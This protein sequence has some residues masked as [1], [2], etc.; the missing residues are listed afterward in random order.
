MDTIFVYLINIV[1][2]GCWLHLI[3]T[4]VIESKWM[5]FPYIVIIF[6]AHFGKESNKRNVLGIVT[7][8]DRCWRSLLLSL[9]NKDV[10]SRQ[11][12]KK[13]DLQIVL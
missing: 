6:Y 5:L 3:W 12:V 11:W 13:Q 9:W 8:E 4:I 1:T 10:L 7:T 2:E